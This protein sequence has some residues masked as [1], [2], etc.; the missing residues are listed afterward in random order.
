MYQRRGLGLLSWLLASLIGCT[1]PAASVDRVDEQPSSDAPAGPE[2]PPLVRPAIP[3]DE[4]AD[5]AVL[6]QF[7]GGPPGLLVSCENCPGLP[8][9]NISVD[10]FPPI[11]APIGTTINIKLVALGFVGQSRIVTLDS[12]VVEV[13]VEMTPLD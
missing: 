3:R 1:G 10:K 12:K 5:D 11:T 7:I 9:G 6:L 4:V 2:T 8:A 13:P